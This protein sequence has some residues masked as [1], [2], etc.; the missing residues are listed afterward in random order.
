MEVSAY[1]PFW[2]K[3]T[4][5]QKR[6][7][8]DSVREVRFPKGKILHG[9]AE[10]CIG[11]LLVTK[12]QLRAFML[13]EEGKELTLYRLFERDICLFSASCMFRDID[14]SLSVEAEQDCTVLHIPQDSYKKLMEQS[15]AVSAYTNEL[16]ASRFSDVMWLMD[17]VLNKKLDA[18]LAALLLE[19]Q[20]LS[21]S[22]SLQVTHERLAHHLGSVR[23]VVTRM[24]Q[25]FQNEGL[26]RLTR[27][28]IELLD[29]SGLKTLAADSLR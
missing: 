19:E 6:I 27:G 26:V 17:Q 13:S 4:E 2:D 23:E 15:L 22:A 14:F 7:L 24:L 28:R 29:V 11:L 20:G 16:M 21:G 18:R 1:L 10:D 3:L 25:Y 8:Q 12:G 9:A 5:Q